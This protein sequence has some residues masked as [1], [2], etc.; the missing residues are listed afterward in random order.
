MLSIRPGPAPSSPRDDSYAVAAGRFRYRLAIAYQGAGFGGWQ[1]QPNADTVQARLEVA[2]SELVGESVTV[3]G[4]GRTDAGVHAQGQVAHVD[5]GR[6][7]PARGL[8]FGANPRLPPTIRVLAAAPAVTGFHAR[9]SAAA[10]EYAYRIRPGR[11]LDPGSAPFV[12]AVP[13][14]LDLQLLQAATRALPGE[15][16]FSCFALAGGSHRSP[17]RT[18]FRAA[19]ESAG[20]DWILRIAGDGFLRGMV[21]G[22]AGTLLDVALG[23]RSVQSFSA[24]LGG[25]ARGEAGPT[26]PAHA[27]SLER[28]DYPAG[29]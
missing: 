28:V 2:F 15:H 13:D 26:A 19:W 9:F 12:L 4:A 18:V 8:V 1:R 21:R 23:R 7:F 25:G 16:D 3:I 24:L 29:Y 10:K 14:R 20:E 5:L 6:P 22:L 27:L 17:V 11:F